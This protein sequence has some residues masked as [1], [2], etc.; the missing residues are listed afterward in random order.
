MK[1]A[2]RRV[3]LIASAAACL[4]FSSAALAQ[5]TVQTQPRVVDTSAATKTV[6]TT[7]DGSQ[8]VCDVINGVTTNCV[9]VAQPAPAPVV[10][11]QPVVYPKATITA[12]DGSTMQ[13]D[14][15]NGTMANCVVVQAAP[16]PQVVYTQPQPA[17]QPQVVVVQQPAAAPQTISNDTISINTSSG[18]FFFSFG[19]G[20]HM[21]LWDT[22][23]DVYNDGS[24]IFGHNIN[25]ELSLGYH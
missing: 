16:Q 14:N 24:N 12:Q 6:I 10:A 20:Y 15:I 23:D 3:S 11:Q 21:L 2:F 8:L 13:C 25:G 18:H 5:D 22:L 17:A 9:P 7:Q 19:V 1:D 4:C